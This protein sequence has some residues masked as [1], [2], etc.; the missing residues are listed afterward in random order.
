VLTDNGQSTAERRRLFGRVNAFLLRFVPMVSPPTQSLDE[1]RLRLSLI[2]AAVG[3]LFTAISVSYALLIWLFERPP[4]IYYAL[5]LEGFVTATSTLLLLRR[6]FLR[7][8]TWVMLGGG[9]LAVLVPFLREGPSSQAACNFTIVVVMAALLVGW[10]G[11]LALGVPIAVMVLGAGILARRGLLHPTPP[12]APY[13][14]F[15][16]IQM[17]SL[18]VMLVIF[19]RVR[20]RILKAHRQLE[21][22]LLQAQRLEAVGRLAGGI[23]HDFNNLLTVILANVSL[24]SRTEAAV[25]QHQ[26]VDDIRQAAERAAQLTRQLLAFS[27]RQKL[28]PRVFDLVALLREEE[29][30][31]RRLIPETIRMEVDSAE[32]PLRVHADPGQLSQVLVNLATNAR[33]AMPD[34][35]TL[36]ISLSRATEIEESGP[37]TDATGG[38]GREL[39]RG[40]F[41]CLRVSDTGAGM[42]PTTIE[43]AFDPFFSTKEAGAG[44]GL[45]LAIVHGIVTQSGGI[46][47]VTSQPGSGTLFSIYLPE[48]LVVPRLEAARGEPESAPG[49]SERRRAI[50]LVEDDGAVRSATA[51]MLESLGHRV[52]ACAHPAEARTFWI[53]SAAEIDLIVSDVILPGVT[54]PRLVAELLASRPVRVLFISGY[55]DDALQDPLLERAAFLP[56]P[57]SR[58]DLAAKVAAVLAASPVA[59]RSPN[60]LTW[61][62]NKDI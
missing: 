49:A 5:A 24:L 30:I 1:D 21:T 3:C 26:E 34:G 59:L 58:R 25:R 36:Q 39:A 45:G 10:R 47:R 35:G 6:G 62:E 32:G 55:L 20:L 38:G 56:K 61:K 22:R 46:V 4:P 43:R 27:R 41:A 42:D 60:V 17:S 9:T 28:E 57:F 53:S 8:A 15:A 29:G 37:Q 11:V 13:G 19:D 33:D 31:L 48:A 18:I 12:T 14:V 23:A 16:L 50:L 54:G 51:R 44:T 52:V 40:A 2:T 7:A